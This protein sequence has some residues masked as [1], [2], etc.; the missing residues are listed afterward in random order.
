MSLSKT[1]NTCLVLHGSNQETSR[2]DLKLADWD[3][4]INTNIRVILMYHMSLYKLMILNIQRNFVE[5]RYPMLIC[6]HVVEETEAM[7]CILII[8]RFR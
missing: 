8:Y 1:F 3:V 6:G 2:H 4:K 5:N 7:S